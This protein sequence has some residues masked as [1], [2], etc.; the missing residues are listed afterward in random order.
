MFRKFSQA[1]I[2]NL[3]FENLKTF[4]WCKRVYV[5]TCLQNMKYV[6][7]PCKTIFTKLFFHETK[8][9]FQ[10]CKLCPIVSEYSDLTPRA[11]CHPVQFYFKFFK[12]PNPK[13]SSVSVRIW[14][15]KD[16]LQSLWFSRNVLFVISVQK[17]IKNMCPV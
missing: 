16:Y 3:F 5:L 1:S 17:Q 15:L 12:S 6:L 10:F 4:Q 14:T 2:S 7:D 11:T 13:C 8:N 9:I